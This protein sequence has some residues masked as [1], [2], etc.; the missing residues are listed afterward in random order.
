MIT[1]AGNQFKDWSANYRLFDKERFKV[2]ELFHTA[3]QQVVK[4][5]KPDQPL[6]G[7][8]DD[9][10]LLKC[11]K[12]IDGTAWRRDPLG[13]P[14]HTNFTWAQRFLQISLSL[15]DAD[16]PASSRAI[17]VD[18]H[19]CPTVTKPG[20]KASEEEWRKYAAL[21]KEAKISNQGA[22]RIQQLRKQFDQ[23]NCHRPLIICGDGGYTNETVI[24][25]LPHQT[26]FIGRIRKDAKLHHLPDHAS[27]VGR[28][29]VYGEQLP[30]PEQIR[31]S[32][33][34]P[35]QSVKAFAAGKPHQFDVKVIKPV[36]WRKAGGDFDLQL[37]VIRPLSYRLT[38]K[39]KLLYR[40]PAYLICTDPELDIETLLQAYL[41][42]WEIE[43]NHKEEKSLIG[44]GEAMVRSKTKVEKVPAFTVAIYGLLHLAA[45]KA[46]KRK[47]KLLLPKP[48][49]HKGKANSRVSTN[50]LLNQLR[51]E[52]WSNSFG[53]NFSDFV[54]QQQRIRSQRNYAQPMAGAIFYTRK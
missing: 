50:S 39:S 4:L 27:G 51:T 44:C 21:Q 37:I 34:I 46:Y 47:D 18:F 38:K 13:P 28:N 3:R 24:K 26:T 9:T 48:A 19:H 49:W 42:R 43:V 31:Q 41:W 14:F 16:G 11:G 20:K 33:D 5:L 36:R 23:D 30:T 25:N 17:P 22:L 40:Q 29:K 32:N 53:M 15:P 7:H 52:L 54:K 2:D 12:K 10:L 35:W 1:A 45:H 6:I 8:I